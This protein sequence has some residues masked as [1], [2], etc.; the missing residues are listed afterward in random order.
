MRTERSR[1]GCSTAAGTVLVLFIL[2]FLGIFGARPRKT[3]HQNGQ[4][5]RLA[6][7]L[8]LTFLSELRQRWS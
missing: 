3:W 5:E 6:Q 4:G 2:G 8:F 1:S 7:H